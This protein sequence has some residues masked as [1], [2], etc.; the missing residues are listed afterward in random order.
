MATLGG[1]FNPDEI[2]QDEF[3][4]IP[5]GDYL[6]QIVD[7]EIAPTKSGS[8]QMLKLTYEILQGELEGRRVWDRLNIVNANADAQRIAQQQLKKLCDALGTGAIS[9][10]EELHF[11]PVIIH[12]AIRQDKSGDY[13]PQNVI[14]KFS[15]AGGGAAEAKATKPTTRTPP[16][17]KPAQTGGRPWQQRAAT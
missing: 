6:A 2:P 9:D 4:P 14:R 10:S 11:R 5:A 8:G 17:P 16:P 12:V 1:T 13:G 15:P 3:E 7:S